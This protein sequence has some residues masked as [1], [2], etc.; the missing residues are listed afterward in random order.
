MII[1]GNRMPLI[2]FVIMFL[3]LF[4]MEKKLRK[5]SFLFISLAI[6]IFLIVFKMSPLVQDYTQYFLRMSIGL[7]IFLKETL[8][9][10]LEPNITNTYIKEFYSGY[11]AW[12]E[13]LIH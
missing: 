9:L 7:F 8:L 10:G 3:V 1:A 11:L 2:L 13:N 4:L 6:I 12:K 5:F